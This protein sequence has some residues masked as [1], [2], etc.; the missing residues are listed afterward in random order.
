[1]S[2]PTKTGA[3]IFLEIVDAFEKNEINL[4]KNLENQEYISKKDH[5]K[6]IQRIKKKKK[7]QNKTKRIKN[8]R[9]I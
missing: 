2:V 7:N 8:I 9:V 5:Q 6:E 3:E 4:C 1:M